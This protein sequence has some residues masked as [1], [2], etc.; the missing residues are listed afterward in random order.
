MV[1]YLRA[2]SRAGHPEYEQ[3][4]GREIQRNEAAFAV[5]SG[6]IANALNPSY[7]SSLNIAQ[8]R[9]DWRRCR[10]KKIRILA[11]KKESK[12]RFIKDYFA[13]EPA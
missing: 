12:L 13:K 4:A 10:M 6:L 8:I 3:F 11:I 1:V 2:F 5:S 7:K 9:K